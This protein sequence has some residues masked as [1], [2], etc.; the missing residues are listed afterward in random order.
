MPERLLTFRKLAEVG[1]VT[2]ME[3]LLPLALR[4]KGQPYTLK[5]HFPF[6]PMYR[7][8]MPA[9]QIW[10]TGRQ[11][12]KTTNMGA[13]G[14]MLSNCK[15]NF[16]TLYCTPLYEQIR[17][18]STNYVRPFI[19]TSPIRSL[20]V[21]TST[22]QSVLQRSFRNG[23]KM[24]FSFALLDADRVRGVSADQIG[25][26]ELQ[27]MDPAHLP[28]IRET[29]SASKYKLERLHGTPKSMEGAVQGAWSRSSQA[30]W[31]IPCLACK[32]W[33]IPGI[34]F[35][36][37][38]MIGPAR[39]DI[40]LQ[41]PGTIC[42]HCRRP[43]NPRLGHWKHRYEDRRWDF[44][45][46][47]IP[48]LI[49]PMHYGYPR[50]WRELC[51][52]QQGWG[53]MSYDR[54][55]NEVLGESTDSGSKLITRTD[56][57]AS[58]TLP[59]RNN[60]E[61]PAPEIFQRLGS[62]VTRVLAVD[63]GGGGEE[64]VSYTA[65]ALMGIDS[66]GKIDVLWG[67]RLLTPNDHLREANEIRHWFNT[68]NCDVLSHDYTG[69]GTVRETVL[70]QSG[71]PIYK[72]MP[73]AYVRAAA[74]AI[75]NHVPPTAIHPR[76]HYRADKTRS[77]LYTVQS[78]KQR[79]V[80]FFQH[81]FVSE[82][83]PGLIEDFLSL[84]EN[85]AESHRGSDVYMIIKADSLSDDFAQAVNLGCLALW[86]VTGN[87]PNFSSIAQ[88]VSQQDLMNFGDRDHGWDDLADSFV[89]VP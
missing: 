46:Y 40:S 58:A 68:F 85:K 25:I 88:A 31:F 7:L 1:A 83:H 62:Y 55:C 17:R 21:S 54:F 56:L 65:I 27:D 89:D 64:G 8:R 69:A 29:M 19:D 45:G 6:S 43:I 51:A 78:I 47:H 75:L 20:W 5:D 60:V 42:Y 28:I 15:S 4:L 61:F 81:D 59:W 44:A 24:L 70:V 74:A 67:K 37:E 12:A 23:S 87:W 48:Q 79:I 73:I 10:K 34:E 72:I 52:K 18:F 30:E 39:D 38:R 53:N 22:E 63:W 36:L 86:H 13:H 71:L 49:L 82:D 57:V 33:N 66:T 16:V 9:K 32:R 84:I 80:R 35:H 26:D 76:D 11:V 3:P 77:L 50:A 2:T 14:S 41:S